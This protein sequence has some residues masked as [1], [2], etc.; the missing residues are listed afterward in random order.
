MDLT[1]PNNYLVEWIVLFR[2]EPQLDGKKA[3]SD[4]I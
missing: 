3:V 1:A 2:L 4:L